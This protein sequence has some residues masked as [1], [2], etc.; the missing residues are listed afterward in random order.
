MILLCHFIERLPFVVC[1][2]IIISFKFQHPSGG[3][4][5]IILRKYYAR[6]IR[7]I[8]TRYNE[9]QRHYKTNTII[10]NYKRQAFN[11]MTQK[12]DVMLECS[13]IFCDMVINCFNYSCSKLVTSTKLVRSYLILLILSHCL[14][15]ILNIDFKYT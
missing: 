13:A 2:M 4:N 12:D 15:R 3:E 14:I 1:A 11:E 10:N 6:K 5:E 9:S 8:S 7:T